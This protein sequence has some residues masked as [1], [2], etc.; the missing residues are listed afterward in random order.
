MRQRTRLSVGVLGR[1]GIG[2]LGLSLVQMA[3]AQVNFSDIQAWAG[4]GQNQAALV[5]DWK[6]GSAPQSQVWGYRWDGAAT[7]AD[8]LAAILQSDR[9]LYREWVPGFVNQAVFGVGLDRNENGFDKND[10]TDSYQEGWFSNGFWAYYVDVAPSTTLPSWTFASSGF[11]GRTLM[12]GSWDGL[13]WAQNYNATA[14]AVPTP[15]SAPVPEP[16][17]WALLVSAAVGSLMLRRKR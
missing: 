17:V 11:D 2:A 12:N 5:I 7:G 15:I 4:T 10:P 13:S 3:Q 16:G 8:M 9:R 1:W 6:S 14:P